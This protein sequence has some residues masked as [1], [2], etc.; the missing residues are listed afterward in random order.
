GLVGGPK[1]YLPGP[2]AQLYGV[3]YGVETSVL[4]Y[5][6]DLFAKY[7]LRPPRTYAELAALLE[8]IR[9]KMRLAALT[10]RGQSGHN[11]VHAW[12]L[13]FNAFGGAFL[14]PSG[15]PVFRSSPECWRSH[16]CVVLRSSAR[17][18]SK[19]SVTPKC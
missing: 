2:G 13:H 6:R 17:P 16:C 8:P 18:V 12:L 19:A 11:C 14:M 3:P 9:E 7:D 15:A 10:S 1:G 4:A 5:R